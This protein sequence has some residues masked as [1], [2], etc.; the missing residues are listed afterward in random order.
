VRKCPNAHPPQKA[1]CTMTMAV[2]E[3]PHSRELARPRLSSTL[4]LNAAAPPAFQA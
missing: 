4:G 1:P 2:I 3:V